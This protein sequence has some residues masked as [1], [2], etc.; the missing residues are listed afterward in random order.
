M[1]TDFFVMDQTASTEQVQSNRIVSA[2]RH[3]PDQ[4]P[5]KRFYDQYMIASHS[6]NTN[7]ANEENAIHT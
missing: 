7:H 5:H 4:V 6:R 1:S 2:A 3:Y